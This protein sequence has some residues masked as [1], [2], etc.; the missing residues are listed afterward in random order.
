MLVP[1]PSL[2]ISFSSLF[3]VSSSVN[4]LGFS[5]FPSF[6]YSYSLSLSLS[7]FISSNFSFQS[8]SFSRL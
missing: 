4:K 8:F 3:C 2:P 5:L 6:S 1:I 7:V